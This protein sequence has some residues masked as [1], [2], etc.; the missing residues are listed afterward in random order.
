MCVR[1]YICTCIYVHIHP[2]PVVLG[3][4]LFVGPVCVDVCMY[5]CVCVYVCTCMYVHVHTVVVAGVCVSVLEM[6]GV[7]EALQTLLYTYIDTY[8]DI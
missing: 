2:P 4:D 3:R 6:C 8:I 1:V 5:V 7:A